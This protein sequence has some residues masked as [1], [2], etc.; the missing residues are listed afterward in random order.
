MEVQ[1]VGRGDL[2]FKKTPPPPPHTHTTDY[3]S[4]SLLSHIHLVCLSTHTHVLTL[5]FQRARTET[6][7]HRIAFSR[8]LLLF[9]MEIAWNMKIRPDLHA[10]VGG[11]QWTMRT[12]D[13]SG[14]GEWTAGELQLS[15]AFTPQPRWIWLWNNIFTRGRG[16]YFF[17]LPAVFM[18]VFINIIFPVTF[19]ITSKVLN[20]PIN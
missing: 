14:G 7:S 11:E 9:F 8:V 16:N 5:T 1:R 13:W 20:P 6:S 17:F 19:P 3:R 2:W 10:L 12:E 18:K 4:S 15:C